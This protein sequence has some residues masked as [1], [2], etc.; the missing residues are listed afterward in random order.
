MR[1]DLGE[2]F[3]NFLSEG[4]SIDQ[5]IPPLDVSETEMDVEMRMDAPGIKP[6]ELDI[7]LVGNALTIS[8]E[9][10]EEYEGKIERFIELS[11]KPVLLVA[12]YFC[13]VQ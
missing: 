5:A 8:G 3:S 7:Q 10:T 12:Q 11:G 1:E 6:G 4:W 13:L 9:R 2:L